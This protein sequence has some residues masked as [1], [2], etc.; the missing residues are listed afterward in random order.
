[1]KCNLVIYLLEIGILTAGFRHV[2]KRSA[3]DSAAGGQETL[4]II[5]RRCGL[6][7]VLG[8]LYLLECI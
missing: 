6:R 1:M 4:I 8:F 2:I 7:S 5:T 3:A